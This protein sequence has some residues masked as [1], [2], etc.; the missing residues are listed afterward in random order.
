[1]FVGQGGPER[2]KRW[3]EKRERAVERYKAQS[4]SG[5][6]PI[7]EKTDENHRE[8]VTDDGEK[9]IQTQGWEVEELGGYLSDEENVGEEEWRR[10]RPNGEL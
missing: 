6:G 1:M 3:L 10:V 2:E 7:T 4:S 5:K 8:D 9:G